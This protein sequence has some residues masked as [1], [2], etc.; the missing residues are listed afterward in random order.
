MLLGFFADSA[1]KPPFSLV[2]AG[3]ERPPFLSSISE[4]QRTAFSVL[5]EPHLQCLRA[6]YDQFDD[7]AEMQR[8]GTTQKSL[9]G[10]TVL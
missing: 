3:G 10:T 1:P 4:G 7:K 6:C 5:G 2:R 9:E 8:G